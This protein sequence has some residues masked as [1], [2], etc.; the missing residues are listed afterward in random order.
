MI[1]LLKIF[2]SVH[3]LKQVITHTKGHYGWKNLNQIS[4]VK[5][6]IKED[7]KDKSFK[8]QNNEKCMGMRNKRMH[9]SNFATILW[10]HIRP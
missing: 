8:H 9:L 7:S 5:E 2:F 10:C 1:G 6:A 3:E 4:K